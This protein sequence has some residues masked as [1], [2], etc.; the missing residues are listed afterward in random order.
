MDAAHL[1]LMINHLPIIGTPVVLAFLVWGLLRR[2]RDIQ[3]A[4][5]GG[6]VILAALTYP[7]FL[8]GEPAEHQVEDAAWMNERLVH[9]HEERAE[10]AL[11]AVLLTGAVALVG[12]WQARRERPLSGK[13]TGVTAA[14][15]LLSA[16]LLG[17][18]ALAGG[19]IRHDET[20]A[21]AVPAAGAD[22]APD[23]DADD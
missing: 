7:V 11:I 10:M 6:A 2:S 16:G 18:T 15:L 23:R 9:E 12:L 1:H 19:V 5:L 21:S 17:W 22:Q 4:A 14:G 20:R 3:R 8:T 13:L